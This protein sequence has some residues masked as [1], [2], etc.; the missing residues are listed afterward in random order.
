MALIYHFKAWS[1]IQNERWEDVSIWINCC[2]SGHRLFGILYSF[3]CLKYYNTNTRKEKFGKINK[4]EAD[5]PKKLIFSLNFN[6]FLCQNVV[7]SHGTFC[8]ERSDIIS[9][10]KFQRIE[11]VLA[12]K[13]GNF[14][15]K[16]CSFGNSLGDFRCAATFA[17]SFS[18]KYF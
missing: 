17:W 15:A 11:W 16:S 4:F 1:K 9:A 5:T 3:Q 2:W 14:G 8:H 7:C 12:E 10:R 13:Y 18:S 6:S